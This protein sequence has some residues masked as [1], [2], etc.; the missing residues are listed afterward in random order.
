[1]SDKIENILSGLEDRPGVYQFYDREGTLLYIGKAKSLRKRV[2]SYFQKEKHENGKTAVLVR[3]IADIK[4]LVVDSEM[5]ALLLENSLIKK[6]QP[7]YNVNLKDDKTY[8]WIC[9]KNERFPRVFVTRKLIKDGSEYFGPYTPVKMINTLL[10]LI[11]QLHKLRNC[12]LN[13]S[14]ENIEAGKF[15][16]CLEYHIG[17][18]KGPCE[19]LQSQDDY[20]QSIKEIR[21]IL[22]GNIQ[23]LIQLLKEKMSD[24]AAGFKYEEAQLMK[25]KVELLERFKSK[26]VLVNPSIHN[27]DVFSIITE[28][29]SAFVNF[30]RIMNGAIVQGHTVEMKRKLDETPEELL[31]IAIAEMRTRFHSDAP[32]IL[33]PFV[34]ETELKGVTFTVPKIGDKKKLL[35]LSEANVKNYIREKNLQL[36]KQNPENRTLRLLEQM[37]ADLR[38]KDLPRRIE[39]FDNSNIQGAFPVAAMSVFIN[40]KPAKKEYRHFNI[41][42]VEGPDDFA[43]MEEVIYRRYKRML[44]EATDLPQLIIIDGG[45]GQLS[46]AMNSLDKLGL[47]GK[48]AVI[49]IAKRLEEIYYPGDSAPLYID[50]KSETL[51]TIQHLRDE[52]HR[53]G[54]TH[55]RNRRSKDLV[56]TEL[57]EI[58][59]IGDKTATQL[60]SHFKSI[61]SL[62]KAGREEIEALVGKSRA[63]KVIKYFERTKK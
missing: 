6:H 45:K 31:E 38:L 8:P 37:K 24:H 19:G 35:S 41:K 10:E 18:C 62:E 40:G 14:E 56:K 17:N 3:K 13:L 9:I 1:M 54:I 2:S 20:D 63:E 25:E 59:G 58:P 7:R 39:C 4:T 51:K 29:D 50:K 32:E 21:M 61:K 28:D 43:S 49:G 15:K 11:S 12:N 55:H 22:K 5:D 30:L 23:M 48:I 53:F 46:A 27:T 36:E 16:V 52:V 60:L 26:S 33:V 44:D 47:R 34:P 42:T 57:S